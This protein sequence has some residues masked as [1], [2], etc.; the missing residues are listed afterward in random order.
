MTLC[1]GKGLV[2]DPG[3]LSLLLLYLHTGP[4]FDHPVVGQLEK[5][6]DAS[7]IARHGGKQRLALRRHAGALPAP[8]A[9]I[10]ISR[11]RKYAAERS[12]TGRQHK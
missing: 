3:A 11:L 2:V 4:E 1:M 8:C 9:G 6:H 12:S 5:V 10:T 7:R